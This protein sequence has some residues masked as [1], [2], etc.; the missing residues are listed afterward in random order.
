MIWFSDVMVLESKVLVLSVILVV[1]YPLND[2]MSVCVAKL[3]PAS[4]WT[5]KTF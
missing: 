5:F 2:K 4:T 3:V 1:S